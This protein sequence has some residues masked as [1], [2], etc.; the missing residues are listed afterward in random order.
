[1]VFLSLT[2]TRKKKKKLLLISNLSTKLCELFDPSGWVDY[3]RFIFPGAGKIGL[4]DQIGEG[5]GE[6][7]FVGGVPPPS[8]HASSIREPTLL[9]LHP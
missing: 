1:M 2:H 6:G 3:G 4:A 9:L 8:I 7:Q 5:E